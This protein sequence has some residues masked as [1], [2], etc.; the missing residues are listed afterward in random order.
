VAAREVGPGAAQ[1]SNSLLVASASPPHGTL[2]YSVGPC[3][4]PEE[5]C[6]SRAETFDAAVAVRLPTKASAKIGD[7]ELCDALKRFAGG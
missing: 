3:P 6:T 1:A 4:I 5:C 2:F 7:I